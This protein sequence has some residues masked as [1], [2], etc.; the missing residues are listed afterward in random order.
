MASDKLQVCVDFDGVVHAHRLPFV[1]PAE[2]PD[3]PVAGAF[4]ALTAYL[5][6]GYAVAIFSC[7]NQHEG[8]PDA[9]RL[10][11]AKHGFERAAELTFPAIKPGAVLY[12]DDRAFCFQGEFP[13]VE[14]I[15]T[16]KTWLGH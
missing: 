3:V 15:G 13:T 5:D 7:R 10:W 8:A 2:I 16:F 11:F 14:A 1:H 12:I 9:M 4:E 6:A